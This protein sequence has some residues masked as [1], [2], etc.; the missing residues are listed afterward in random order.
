MQHKAMKF[1]EPCGVIICNPEPDRKQGRTAT[2]PSRSRASA[3]APPVYVSKQEQI[4][5]ANELLRVMSN[6]KMF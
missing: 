2:A 5:R 6:M 1:S 3:H 4:K